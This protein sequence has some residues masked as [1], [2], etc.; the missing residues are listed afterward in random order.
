MDVSPINL[1]DDLIGR[2][3]HPH[4]L[5]IIRKMENMK[6]YVALSD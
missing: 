3:F 2:N 4:S 6:G 1:T 5:E